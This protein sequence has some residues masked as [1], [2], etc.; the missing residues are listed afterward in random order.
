MRRNL[1]PAQF[2]APSTTEWKRKAA[3]AS[4]HGQAIPAQFRPIGA[5]K[6]SPLVNRT[7]YERRAARRAR[8]GVWL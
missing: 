8:T 6:R 1:S 7:P 4:I 3:A 2:A 5:D